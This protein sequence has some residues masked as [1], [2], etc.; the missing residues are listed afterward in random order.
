MA[1]PRR[2]QSGTIGLSAAR[3]AAA[4]VQQAERHERA[5]RSCLSELRGVDAPAVEP[6]EAVRRRAARHA[7]R[8]VGLIRT[9]IRLNP[10]PLAEAPLAA[11]LERHERNALLVERWTP[12][13]PD[14]EDVPRAG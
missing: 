8:A 4:A 12:G 13:A 10:D 1:E 5:L 9:A 6:V 3:V 7:G 11:L 2:N 14:A